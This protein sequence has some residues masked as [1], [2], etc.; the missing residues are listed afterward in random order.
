MPF[1]GKSMSYMSHRSLILALL[2]ASA[3]SN[4]AESPP[5]P[6]P[7]TRIEKIVTPAAN[8]PVDTLLE[9][10][11]RVTD[12]DGMPVPGVEVRWIG[13][14]GGPAIPTPTN[15]T[16][17]NG[18]N[19]AY[20][21]I[22]AAAKTYT[23]S[24][25]LLR[26]EGLD[27]VSVDVTTFSVNAVAAALDRLTKAGGDNQDSFSDRAPQEAATV[28]AEDRY[29]NPKSGITVVWTGS[30]N[31]TWAPESSVTGADGKASA[32]WSGKPSASGLASL[33]ATA[34]TVSTTFTGRVCGPVAGGC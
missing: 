32:Q 2:V 21:W 33:T 24:V 9:P 11:I 17:A 7:P 25:H 28:I 5:Q 22:G 16:D 29:G 20:W 15:L 12:R 31:I 14:D 4:P 19:G 1:V 3:C 34:G 27:K 26:G 13:A 23:M 8:V 6:G 30:P 10:R 18:E